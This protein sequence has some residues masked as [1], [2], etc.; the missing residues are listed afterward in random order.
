MVLPYLVVAR[1]SGDPRDGAVGCGFDL[2]KGA[3]LALEQALDEGI[4]GG[5][6]RSGQGLGRGVDSRAEPW[7]SSPSGPPSRGVPAGLAAP[8]LTS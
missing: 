3:E 4:D 6:A 1:C 8:S 5:P 2:D 7:W